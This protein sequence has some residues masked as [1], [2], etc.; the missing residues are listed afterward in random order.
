MRLAGHTCIETTL[1]FYI[2]PSANH[3]RNA[4]STLDNQRDELKLIK[5]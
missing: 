5:G 1:N 4:I 2:N 3:L